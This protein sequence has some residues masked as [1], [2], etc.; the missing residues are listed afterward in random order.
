[1]AR[2]FINVAII[3]SDCWCCPKLQI[4]ILLDVG[5]LQ[6]ISVD[7]KI[8]YP[9]GLQVTYF[10]IANLA[11]VLFPP[12]AIG[13]YQPLDKGIIQSLEVCFQKAQ[14]CMLLSQYEIWQA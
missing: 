14:L 2:W 10:E 3:S 9:E 8:L 4:N 12:S 7:S 1:M 6:F 13:N 11:I 5:Q